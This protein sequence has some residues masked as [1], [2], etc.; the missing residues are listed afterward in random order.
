MLI[1]VFSDTHDRLPKIHQAIELF[2]D[3]NVQAVLHAGDIVAPFAAK[4]LAAID[5][6][7]YVIYGNNDGEKRGL[8][9]VLPQ[10]TGGPVEIELGGKLIAMAHDLADIPDNLAR[11]VD[12]LIGGHTHEALLSKAGGKLR[13]NPGECCGYVTGKCTVAV[14]DTDAIE[15]QIVEMQQ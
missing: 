6:P 4:V 3:R 2:R 8:K 10:I 9:S 14:L 1:G 15:A 5:V 12:I 11:R 13:L 7:L